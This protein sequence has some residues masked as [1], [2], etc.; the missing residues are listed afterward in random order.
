[1]R[2]FVVVLLMRRRSVLCIGALLLHQVRAGG[3]DQRVEVR[4][5]GPA[6]LELEDDSRGDAA[7]LDVGDRLVDTVE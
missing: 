6:L 3:G 1:M 2:R 7:G 5:S 4:V